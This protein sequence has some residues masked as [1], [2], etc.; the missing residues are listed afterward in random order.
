M[1]ADM[2]LPQRTLTF[3][4][5]FGVDPAGQVTGVVE[6]VST[7]QKC[8]FHGFAEISLLMERMAREEEEAK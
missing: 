5:R 3:I 6:R 1:H 2:D 4:I 7:G 8:R